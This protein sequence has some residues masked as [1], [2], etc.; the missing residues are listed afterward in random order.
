MIKKSLF[1]SLALIVPLLIFI[2]CAEDEKPVAPS[3]ELSVVLLAGPQ[4]EV[5]FNAY[6]TYKW[7][8]KGGSGE[9]SG[10]NYSLTR[11]GNPVESGTGVRIN[12]VTFSNLAPGAYTFSVTVVDAKSGDQASANRQMT[13]M[14]SDALPVVS[15]DQSPLPG[16]ELAE[17]SSA[18]FTWVADDPD[19]FFGVVTGYL[20]ELMR[21]TVVVAEATQQVTATSITIDSL[22][23][24]DYVFTVT[25]FNN[26]GHSASDSVKF[27]VT[28]AK[29]LWIDD[30]YQG[31]I[32]AE[33]NEYQERVVTFEG[34]SWMEYDVHDGA[35]PIADI[36]ALLNDPGSTIETIIWDAESSGSAYL[37]YLT[38]AYVYGDPYTAVAEW[39][40]AGGNAIFIGS[41]VNDWA[42]E[43]IPPAE[44]D[45]DN[46]YMGLA[47]GELEVITADTTDTL[48]YDEDSGLWV[49]SFYVTFDTTY[50]DPW[51]YSGYSTLTGMN[52]YS[53]ISLDVGKD[54]STFQD[55]YVYYYFGD[56]DG[57]KEITHDD[58]LDE[59]AG[60]VY[61]NGS[62]SIVAV[63]G[64]NLYYSPTAE[65]KAVIQKILVDEIGM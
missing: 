60:Y 23:V 19:A 2:G 38:G 26:A 35:D 51:D 8:A 29:I 3:S 45:F 59:P 52:G 11:D 62:G 55:S 9:Y 57:V 33:F 16:G 13:V 28:P 30:Y 36:D 6:V 34:Y 1:I 14:T 41:A 63:L 20:Y 49:P 58:D 4:G 54:P 46:L 53:N 61:D 39:L 50:F 7:Q 43:N 15:I 12:T 10:Y 64:Y 24:G 17:Y 5:P 25:A 18:T 56:P 22:L 44:G 48:I 65:Y 42:W 37:Y 47:A 27:A 31:S 32:P 40:D 21:D